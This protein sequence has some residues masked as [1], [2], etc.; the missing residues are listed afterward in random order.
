MSSD[1]NQCNF[2]GHLGKDPDIRYMPDGTA[3]AAFSIAVGWKTKD[4]EGTE[5]I[6]ITAFGKLAEIIGKYLKK[7]SQVFIQGRYKTDKYEKDGQN[8][9]ITKIV[10]EKMQMLGGGEKKGGHRAAP[11]AR[12]ADSNDDSFDDHDIPF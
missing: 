7:G 5:W 2:I 1:L 6:N 12:A 11:E 10:A 3:V 4:K 9:Y 8:R